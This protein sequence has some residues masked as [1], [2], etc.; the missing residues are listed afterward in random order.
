[1]SLIYGYSLNDGD[2]GNDIDS[3]NNALIE[4]NKL[5]IETLKLANIVKFKETVGQ[6][7]APTS[8]EKVEITGWSMSDN[9]TVIAV[10][11]KAKPSLTG[12]VKA[13]V[14]SGVSLSNS[15]HLMSSPMQL[16]LNTI[17]CTPTLKETP[18][19]LL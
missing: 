3:D 6:F 9:N 4:K 18:L 13:S 19:E 11:F 12:L 8:S 16:I 15:D 1:M 2:N 5:D 17:K 10:L 14:Y 7:I